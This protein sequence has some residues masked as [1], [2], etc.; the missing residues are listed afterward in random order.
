LDGGAWGFGLWR[1]RLFNINFPEKAPYKGVRF[2]RLGFRV[3]QEKLIQSVKMEELGKLAGGVAVVRVGAATEVEMK[4]KKARIE[5]AL[6]A[7]RAAVE[8][9]IVP[10]G[11]VAFL[12]SLSAIDSLKLSGD[13]ATGAQIVR[14]AL[15]E[16]ARRIALNAGSD[17]SVV[18]R[19]ILQEKGS[20]GF[21]AD[22]GEYVD[23]FKAGIVDPLKVTRTALENAVSLVG[24]ILTTEVL[25]ADIPEKKEP[26][27]AGPH[28]H[29]G[30]MY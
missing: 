21:N 22:T 30:D 25:V 2:T 29:G 16:P 24:T 6:H 10:G 11:G 3:Y 26:M 9:G 8:E 4:E 23:L 19:R 5:D 12:R 28:G 17:G 18:V 1:N 15:E 7:T 20:V 13:E 14:R 27:P